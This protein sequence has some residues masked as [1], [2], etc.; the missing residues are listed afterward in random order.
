MI[1]LQPREADQGTKYLERG[2]IKKS[3]TEIGRCL[4]E[5]G[6]ENSCSWFRALKCSLERACW[7]VRVGRWVLCCSVLLCCVFAVFDPQL[8]IGNVHVTREPSIAEQWYMS[9]FAMQDDDFDLLNVTESTWILS[10]YSGNHLTQL[11]TSNTRSLCGQLVQFLRHLA[12]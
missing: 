3:V 9:P 8:S 7:R 6:L 10:W 5:L 4:Q 1:S 12:I 11:M 2:R